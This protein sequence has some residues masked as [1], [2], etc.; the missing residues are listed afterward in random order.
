ML[1]AE[2]AT[3]GKRL[4]RMLAIGCAGVLTLGITACGGGAGG[5]EEF[6]SEQ[7]EIIVPWDA[8]GGTDQVTRQLVGAAEDACGTSIIVSNQ[9][10]GGGAV[11][12]QAMATSEPDGY[13]VG[14]ATVEISILNH[15]GT[16]DVTP[17]DLQGVMQYQASPAALS[18]PDDSPY[19]TIDDL[20]DALES[21]EQVRVGTNGRGGIWDIAAGGMAQETGAE[22]SERV[23]FD[24]GAPTISAALGGQIEVVSAS[25]PEMIGQIESG[26]L[27]PLVSMGEERQDILP[28]TPT[29]QENDIDWT[30]G[31]WFGLTVP[32]ET[33]QDRIQ[34]LNECFE[35]AYNSEE[36]TQFMEDQ[37]YGLEYRSAEEFETYM[38]E[39]FSLY[40]EVVERIY[41]E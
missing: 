38:D 26:D 31:N 15:L 19:E 10:G 29:L 34:T 21:D 36:F 27:R 22:F 39:E 24:G 18:V 4:W 23:P 1:T 41:D 37:G 12:H 25:A 3:R 6:P 30:A 32:N 17:E 40:G 35:Q 13:T 14:A 2:C 7:I 20:I 11:G 28:D 5:D 8:G 33:P 16:T 9:G